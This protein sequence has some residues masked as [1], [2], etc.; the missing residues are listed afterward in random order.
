MDPGSFAHTARYSARKRPGAPPSLAR[1][2]P[3]ARP[4]LPPHPHLFAG[5]RLMSS[6]DS[7][8]LFSYKPTAVAAFHQSPL[9]GA[10][11]TTSNCTAWRDVRRAPQLQRLR[12]PARRVGR[13]SRRASGRER[14]PS[15][16]RT[17]TTKKTR[18]LLLPPSTRPSQ[19]PR[20]TLSTSP[21]GCEPPA[22]LRCCRLCRPMPWLLS[23]AAPR[24]EQLCTPPGVSRSC[25]R[26]VPLRAP[27][28]CCLK[29]SES[30]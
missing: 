14:S 18:C 9:P 1:L 25:C 16:T 8:D 6:S 27:R 23:F 12:R 19:H 11:C 29:K 15:S 24:A 4:K 7:E 26:H 3:P 22:A 17:W 20:P 5:R 10:L 30:C 28:S 21:S 2:A 13:T